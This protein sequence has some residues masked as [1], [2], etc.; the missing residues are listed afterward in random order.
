M[1]KR[2]TPKSYTLTDGQIVTTRQ[3]A[4]EMGISESAA[5]NRLIA[6]NDPKKV[7]APYKQTRPPSKM[8]SKKD[9]VL[10]YE[11]NLW[12]LVMR[13]IGGKK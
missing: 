3:V 12:K 4:D 10:P 13:T 7:F 2:R 5:R 1:I 8:T 9:K 11:D 6:H